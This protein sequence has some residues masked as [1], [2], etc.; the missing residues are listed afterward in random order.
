M[1]MISAEEME[2]VYQK[3]VTKAITDAD[4]RKELLA[5][6]NQAI[7]KETGIPVP[8]EYRIRIIEED[9]AYMGT[10]FLPAYTGGELSDDDMMAI[11]GGAACGNKGNC[12]GNVKVEPC[13]GRVCGANK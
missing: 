6:P 7:E 12:F 2:K 13:G 11:A 10:F 3:V 4:F 8:A 1:A 9:P 5:N